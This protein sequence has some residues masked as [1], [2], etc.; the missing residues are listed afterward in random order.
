MADPMP[1]R[2]RRRS[3]LAPATAVAVGALLWATVLPGE[4]D[5]AFAVL[6]LDVFAVAV[7]RLVRRL[8]KR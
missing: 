1:E 5:L 2:P 6:V 8:R 4:R 3:E 7:H